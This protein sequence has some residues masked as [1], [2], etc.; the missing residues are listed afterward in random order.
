MNRVESGGLVYDQF[1]IF[2]DFPWLFHGCFTR[3]GGVSTGP[4]HGLNAGLSSGD[5]PEAVEE[6]RRLILEESGGDELVILS[7]VHGDTIHIHGT[8]H[9]SKTP[10]EADAVITDTPGAMLSILTADCQ[11]IMLVDP[12]K[13]VVANVHSGWRG[14][15]Q[16]VVGKTVSK[17]QESFGSLPRDIRAAIGPS[18]GPCCA[19]FVHYRKELPRS[20]Y[21]H[22]V[23]S[24]HF[25]FW[26]ITR[27]QLCNAGVSAGK[28]KASLAC[29]RCEH[30]EYYSYRDR[31]VTGRMAS[32]IGIRQG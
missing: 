19:E 8:G 23:G 7:Q 32:V 1:P 6:N 24:N 16:N 2:S 21:T 27:D 9:A 31:K 29:T 28:I 11:P 10:V 15:V 17:M 22:R 26:A 13:R 14:S 3:K 18:L 25:D 12:V 4:F 30:D 20:F 5:A